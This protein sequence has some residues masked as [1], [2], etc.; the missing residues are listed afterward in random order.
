MKATHDG[1]CQLCGRMQKLPD[2]RLA[3]HGYTTRWGFFQ[4][5]CPGYAFP[6]LKTTGE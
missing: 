2:G 1:E 6:A 5:V 3:K 4:G